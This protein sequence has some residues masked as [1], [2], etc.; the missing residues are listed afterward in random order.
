[1]PSRFLIDSGFPI[2]ND[3]SRPWSAVGCFTSAEVVFA[4][5][6]VVTVTLPD[7]PVLYFF[8][9]GFVISSTAISLGCCIGGD[10]LGMGGYAQIVLELVVAVIFFV[11]R[12]SMARKFLAFSSLGWILWLIFQLVAKIDVCSGTCSLEVSGWVLCSLSEIPLLDNGVVDVC[13][14]T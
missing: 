2:V 11:P 14:T 7:K 5:L 10:R 4:N 1:M 13:G 12:N 8:A 3:T 9:G 6:F